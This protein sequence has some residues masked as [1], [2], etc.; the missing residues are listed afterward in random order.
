MSGLFSSDPKYSAYLR[1]SLRI[2]ADFG[3]TI[4]APVVFFV[5]IGQWLDGRY[6][7]EPLFTILAFALSACLSGTMIYRKAKQYN[8]EYR[9]IE[10]KPPQG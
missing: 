8:E 2:I 4:A 6:H 1:L 3:A 9:N 5:L 10:T 7:R